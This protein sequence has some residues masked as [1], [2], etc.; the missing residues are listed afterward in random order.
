MPASSKLATATYILSYVAVK[1]PTLVTTATIA[2]VVK[3]HPT[4]VRQLVAALAR[5]R[6]LRSVR[7]ARGGVTLGRPAETISLRDIYE[8]VGDQSL[9]TLTL[10]DP[11]SAWADRC[12]VH[13]TLTKLYRDF[14]ERMLVQLS[15]Y[16]L[17]QMFTP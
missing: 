1:G 9:L 10:K 2:K 11:F 5:A 6:L 16:R 7:G 14:E 4:R 13:P 8:A 12:H 17:S 15:D 3:E